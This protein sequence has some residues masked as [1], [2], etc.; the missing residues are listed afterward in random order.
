MVCT[1]PVPLSPS[2]SLSL[3]LLLPLLPL[4]L[5][6]PTAA[7]AASRTIV[8]HIKPL[9]F[10]GNSVFALRFCDGDGDAEV[11]GF[12]DALALTSSSL[13]GVGNCIST[14]CTGPG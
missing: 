2:F 11:N 10:V 1:V 3:L 6:L 8:E 9:S 4:L 14:K 5:E 12:A 13:Y 7:A